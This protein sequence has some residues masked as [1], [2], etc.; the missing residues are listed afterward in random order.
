MANDTTNHYERDG[1][2]QWWIVSSGDFLAGIKHKAKAP[3]SVEMEIAFQIGGQMSQDQLRSPKIRNM[4]QEALYKEYEAGR[5]EVTDWVNLHSVTRTVK[6]PPKIYITLE[7]PAEAW[8]TQLKN[9][10][11]KK[12]N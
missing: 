9:W 1:K 2:G 8:Q 12:E 11:I 4:T 10:G 3:H 6:E 7:I 5:K